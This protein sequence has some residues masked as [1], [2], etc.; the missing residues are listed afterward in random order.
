[1][2]RISESF[3]IEVPAFCAYPFS[4][5][6]ISLWS[7]NKDRDVNNEKKMGGPDRMCGIEAEQYVVHTVTW[8]KC[9]TPIT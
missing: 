3:I 4:H 2:F 1:M 7:D 8:L 5:T 6:P 9:E